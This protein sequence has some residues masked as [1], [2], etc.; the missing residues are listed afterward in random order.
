M[1][2]HGGVKGTIKLSPSPSLSPPLNKDN[3]PKN[4]RVS[5][6]SSGGSGSPIEDESRIYSNKIVTNGSQNVISGAS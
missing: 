3:I 2:Q 5:P 1:L 4:K 6:R